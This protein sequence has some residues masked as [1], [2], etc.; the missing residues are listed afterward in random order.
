MRSQKAP[1]AYPA[2]RITPQA[3]SSVFTIS[4][5]PPQ[6][7]RPQNIPTH[8]TVPTLS[9]VSNTSSTITS[10]SSAISNPVA[11]PNTAFSAICLLNLE[12]VSNLQLLY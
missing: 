10:I 11:T 6:P 12:I 7:S 5:A 1:V 2:I 8:P 9:I 3:S 4:C